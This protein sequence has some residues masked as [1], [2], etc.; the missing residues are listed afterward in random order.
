MTR[1]RLLDWIELAGDLLAAPPVGFPHER[2]AEQMLRSFEVTT[3]SWEWREG[4]RAYGCQVFADESVSVPGDLVAAWHDGELIERHALVQWFLTTGDSA[5]QSLARVPSA[6]GTAR[7]RGWVLEMLRP[8]GCH[9]QLSIPYRLD[10]DA[11]GAFVLTRP[12][13]EFA[14]DDLELA[15]S[16]QRLLQGIHRQ[17]AALSGA[18][19]P[20]GRQAAAVFALTGSETAVLTLLAEGHTAQAI[21]TRLA[22]SPRTVSKHLEHIYRKMGVRD[23]LAAVRLAGELGR[24]RAAA[25]EPAHPAATQGPGPAAYAVVRMAGD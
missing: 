16:L 14:E 20:V 23:R 6:I 8:V 21:A 10:A 5:A 9:D 15:R 18:G 7:D 25:S 17:C 12:D 4:P 13:S 19:S 2:L 11:Y 1:D 22:C 24:L 3:V